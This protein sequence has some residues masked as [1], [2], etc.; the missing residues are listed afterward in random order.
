MIARVVMRHR[1][2]YGARASR[3][4]GKKPGLA[5]M[6]NKDMVHITCCMR[7]DAVAR[8]RSLNSY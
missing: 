8:R 4:V 7:T 6:W 2:Q 1:V 3:Q 5:L